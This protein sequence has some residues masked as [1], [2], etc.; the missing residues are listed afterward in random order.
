MCWAASIRPFVGRDFV[1]LNL[2]R[3]VEV[4]EPEDIFGRLLLR[5]T[6]LLL[7]QSLHA[8]TRLPL[9]LEAERLEYL[10]EPLDLSLRLFPV[11]LEHLLGLAVGG[12]AGHLVEGIQQALL[13]VV[14]VLQ[15]VFEQLIERGEWHAHAP[16][17]VS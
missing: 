12:L 15:V 1:A 2:L 13:S 5:E 9:G 6:L 4:V 16:F 14:D 8:R 11:L 3:R 17:E 7:D 10:V